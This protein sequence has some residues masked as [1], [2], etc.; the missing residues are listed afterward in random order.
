MSNLEKELA[1]KLLAS[2]VLDIVQYPYSMLDRRKEDLLKDYSNIGCGTMG[3]ASLGGG[4]LTGIYRKLPKFDLSDM[5]NAFYGPIFKEPGFSQIQKL[6]KIMDDISKTRNNVPLAQIAINWCLAH[7][8]M[9]SSLTG[10]KN[11]SEAN[12]NCA[13]A[14]WELMPEE[15]EALDDTIAKLSIY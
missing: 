8:F 11:F 1:D 3:Y 9:H 13:A 6:L 7:D 14:S 2:N 12:D 4:M 10:V 15:M 5:R